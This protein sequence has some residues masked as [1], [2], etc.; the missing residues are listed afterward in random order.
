MHI[1]F[2]HL[3]NT[4]IR[5]FTCVQL[6]YTISNINKYNMQLAYL[7]NTIS[8]SHKYDCIPWQ[9]CWRRRPSPPSPRRPPGWTG[10]ATGATRPSW[11]GTTT[12]HCTA[13]HCTVLH[14]TALYCTTLHCTALYC[15]ALYCTHHALYQH[16]LPTAGTYYSMG[17]HGTTPSNTSRYASTDLGLI[18]MVGLDLNRLDKEQLA[19]LDAGGWGINRL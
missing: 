9:R 6:P 10:G 5:R 7:A 16:C 4:I 19:W 12:L 15:T 13:L 11:S 18:H 8:N 3:T 1:H 17:L 2:P 14:C